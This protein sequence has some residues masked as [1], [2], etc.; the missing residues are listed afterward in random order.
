L[1]LYAEPDEEA[2]IYYDEPGSIEAEVVDGVS[3]L[4]P[5]EYRGFEGFNYKT[6][7]KVKAEEGS[8]WILA[9][10]APPH[11]FLTN[12]VT[13]GG[14]PASALVS[15]TEPYSPLR[16]GPSTKKAVIKSEVDE[17]EAWA[18]KADVPAGALYEVLARCGDW[19]CVGRRWYGG[20]WLPADA[21]GLSLLTL[22]TDD[23]G[24]ELKP[25]YVPGYGGMEC[26]RGF[27]KLE[28]PVPVE[29]R[30]ITSVTFVTG[31]PPRRF[32]ITVDPREAWGKGAE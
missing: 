27:F 26:G 22:T 28:L 8:G 12:F 7:L 13:E 15:F 3:I 32:R 9:H 11:N 24:Y 2:E 19:L 5:Y 30:D 20:A 16:E 23:A 14:W 18:L 1:A 25:T 17:N 21:P 6:W 29:R 4:T 31:A 10:G